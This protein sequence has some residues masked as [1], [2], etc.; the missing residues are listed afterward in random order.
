MRLVSAA[1]AGDLVDDCMIA[2]SNLRIF[3]V[4]SSEHHKR[5]SIVGVVFANICCSQPQPLFR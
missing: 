5:T 4:G 2:S 3:I 1:L